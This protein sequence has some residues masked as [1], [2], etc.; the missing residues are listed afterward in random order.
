MSLREVDKCDS[1]IISLPSVTKSLLGQL[2]ERGEG[3]RQEE[4]RIGEHMTI[5]VI[6]TGSFRRPANEQLEEKSQRQMGS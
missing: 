4:E 1:H 2:G 3:R 6:D 5:Y